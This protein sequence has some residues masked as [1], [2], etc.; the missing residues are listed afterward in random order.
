MTER[1]LN[2]RLTA[3][4]HRLQWIADQEARSAWVKGIFASG[5]LDDERTRLIEET[6]KLVGQLADMND[7]AAK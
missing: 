5:G 1:E 6:E 3:I 2:E 4:H 7:L